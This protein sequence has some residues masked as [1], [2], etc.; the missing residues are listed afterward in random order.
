MRG[1]RGLRP[2]IEDALGGAGNELLRAFTDEPHHLRARVIIKAPR[3]KDLRDLFAELAIALKRFLDFAAN[4][5]VQALTKRGCL[6]LR[7]PA[8]HSQKWLCH[9]QRLRQG[10]VDGAADGALQVCVRG[11]L[12]R[13]VG[14]DVRVIGRRVAKL[15]RSVL[16]PYGR[17][18]CIR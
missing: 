5:G 6:R 2:L 4:G 11:A 13:G 15:G 14:G 8:P 10:A 7:F 18:W 1:Q 3:R 9:R 12:E 16:R 17:S